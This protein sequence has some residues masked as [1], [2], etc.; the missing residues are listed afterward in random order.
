MDKLALSS[1]PYR[2]VATLDGGGLLEF[3]RQEKAGMRHILRPASQEPLGPLDRAMIVMAPWCNRIGGGGF[4]SGARFH[5]IAPNIS[6]FPM[7]L[8]GTAFQS[9][10]DLVEHREDRVSLTLD[11]S[12]PGPGPFRYR[13][14]LTYRLSN[15]QLSVELRLT[16]TTLEDLPFGIGLHP[17]FVCDEETRLQFVSTSMVISDAS[18]LPTHVEPLVDDFIKPRNLPEGRVDNTFLGWTGTAWLHHG[19]GSVGLQSSA[20]MLHVFSPQASAGFCCLEPSTAP[21]NAPNYAPSNRKDLGSG[22][23]ISVTA[24]IFCDGSVT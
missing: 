4:T 20:P 14:A 24:A 1:G 6:G 12:G 15:E 22:E 21:P 13:A 5:P 2:A 9:G 23:V 3:S 11:A 10:W 8:H 7:P 19:D 18:G 17:W 16:N